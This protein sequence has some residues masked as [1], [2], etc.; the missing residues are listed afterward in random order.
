[1]QLLVLPFHHVYP[2]P[3]LILLVLRLIWI[4]NMIV[5]LLS[6]HSYKREPKALWALLRLLH[7]VVPLLIQ[8]VVL[9][10]RIFIVSV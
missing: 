3:S 2:S 9:Q 1:M 7:L 4:N 8:V 6:D 5:Y 10:K